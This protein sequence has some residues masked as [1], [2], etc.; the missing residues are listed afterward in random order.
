MT[1]SVSEVQVLTSFALSARHVI[2]ALSLTAGWQWL[3]ASRLSVAQLIIICDRSDPQYSRWRQTDLRHYSPGIHLRAPG[4][5]QLA[6]LWNDRQSVPA[7]AVGAERGGQADHTDRSAWA[8]HTSSKGTT[9]VARSTPRR[10]QAGRVHIQ[11]AA[12]P[13]TTVGLLVGWLSAH[14]RRKS[15]TTV[16]RHV[17]INFAVPRTRT[18]LGDRSFAVA[19]PQI[20]NS[21]PAD[22]RL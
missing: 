16:V 2:S 19:G 4:L 9:L 21:L 12:R 1:V 22:L 15:P 7:S 10:L 18:R 20:W 6:A 17:Y 13:D 3:T 8:H 14:L 5:L 11:D